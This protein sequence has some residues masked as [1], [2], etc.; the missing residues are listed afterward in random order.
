MLA[1]KGILEYKLELELE[2][3]LRLEEELSLFEVGW[4]G[5]EVERF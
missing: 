1:M 5:F 3:L 2:F 4:G